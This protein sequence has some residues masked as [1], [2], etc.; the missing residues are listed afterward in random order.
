MKDYLEY[1]HS[2]HIASKKSLPYYVSWVSKFYVFC[3]KES[4]EDVIVDEIENFFKSLSSTCEE[5]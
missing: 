5:W 4:G 3:N 2:K 1:L